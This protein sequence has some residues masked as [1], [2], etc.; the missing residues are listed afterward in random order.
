MRPFVNQ[1]IHDASIAMLG[2]KR[3][4]QHF[5]SHGCNFMNDGW[6]VTIPP[7][8][9]Q[10]EIPPFIRQYAC[11]M[12]VYSR[13]KRGEETNLWKPGTQSGQ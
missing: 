3:G 5:H 10:M 9:I 6:I 11:F 7:T 8:P 12:L 2:S 4:T 13:Q 1:L